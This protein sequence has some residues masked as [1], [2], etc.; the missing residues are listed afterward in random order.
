[1]H[2]KCKITYL[3]YTGSIRSVIIETDLYNFGNI[4]LPDGNST[5]CILKIEKVEDNNV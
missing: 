3:H 1:M 5:S 4:T 2:T